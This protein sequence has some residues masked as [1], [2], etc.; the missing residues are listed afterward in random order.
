MGMRPDRDLHRALLSRENL[1]L[2]FE[3]A[4]EAF[5]DTVSVF[6]EA[7]CI[8]AGPQRNVRHIADI[9]E[10]TDKLTGMKE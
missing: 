10:L 6:S 9:R 8:R 7:G 4:V 3:L 2:L 1:R 5:N